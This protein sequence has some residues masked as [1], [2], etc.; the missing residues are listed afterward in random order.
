[1]IDVLD[2]HFES[3]MPCLF[4]IMVQF[5]YLDRQGKIHTMRARERAS[6][7]KEEDEKRKKK[8]KN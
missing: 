1:M 4:Q 3:V 7:S 6:K 2:E 8:C 5:N